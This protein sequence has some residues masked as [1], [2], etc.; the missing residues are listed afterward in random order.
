MKEIKAAREGKAA[1]Q[2]MNKEEQASADEIQGNNS[3][4]P[5]NCGKESKLRKEGEGRKEEI[6]NGES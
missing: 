6:F 2:E 1:G 3:A 5:E 4:N